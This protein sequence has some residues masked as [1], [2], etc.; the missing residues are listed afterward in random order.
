MFI[1]NNKNE[2]TKEKASLEEEYNTL[3]KHEVFD[4]EE[5]KNKLE[6]QRTS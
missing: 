3:K 5:E 4:K 6:S 1:E 2:L